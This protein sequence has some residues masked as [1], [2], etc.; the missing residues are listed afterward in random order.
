VALACMVP[1]MKRSKYDTCLGDD[2]LA[3]CYA[4]ERIDGVRIP[5]IAADL[6][7]RMPSALVTD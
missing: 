4:S 1:D 3:H 2:L 6:L 7:S 5:I